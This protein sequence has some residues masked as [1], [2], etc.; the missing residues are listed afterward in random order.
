MK[1]LLTILL[2]AVSIT[3]C[4]KEKDEPA[5]NPPPPPPPPVKEIVFKIDGEETGCSSCASA[6]VALGAPI[7]NFNF[8]NSDD[9]VVVNFYLKPD[10]GTY[11][12]KR[13]NSTYKDQIT[14]WI[15][16]DGKVYS[17]VAGSINITSSATESNGNI[18]RLVAG[19]S[20]VSDTID[21]KFLTV[22]D[23]TID[24]TD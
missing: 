17:A 3:Y 14:L 6:F 16:K 7:M 23:G 24:F 12:L 22:T 20:F 15:D 2:L 4:K 10:P 5:K 8:P 18:K 13:N 9:L 1:R 21:G 19:F 11:P